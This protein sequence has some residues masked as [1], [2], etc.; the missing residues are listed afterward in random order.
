MI[1][2]ILLYPFIW[3]NRVLAYRR[4]MRKNPG[5][6]TDLKKKVFGEQHRLSLDPK[7]L[8]GRHLFIE[9]EKVATPA[10]VSRQLKSRI[11]SFDEVT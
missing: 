1:F 8:T 10:E 6:D 9:L 4:A 7:V 2:L 3:L 11:D 5:I